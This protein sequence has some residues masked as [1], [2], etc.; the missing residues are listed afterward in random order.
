MTENSHDELLR[1]AEMLGLPTESGVYKPRTEA[2]NQLAI[3]D[4]ELLRRIREE[5]RHR[6]ENRLWIVAVAYMSSV[7]KMEPRDVAPVTLT[8]CRR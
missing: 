8:N 3:T 1:R 4:Y 6:R 7:S 2:W 5:E